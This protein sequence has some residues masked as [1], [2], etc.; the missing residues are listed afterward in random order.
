MTDH[1]DRFTDSGR[2]ALSSAYDEAR[3]LHHAYIGTEHLLLGL[4]AADDSVAGRVLNQAG[5]SLARARAAVE[6]IVGPGDS[7]RPEGQLELT[8]RAKQVVELAMDEARRLGHDDI[9]T[10]HLTLGLI[11]EGEGVA[12]GVLNSMK[13]DLEKLRAE[14]LADA[15]GTET[16]A[17]APGLTRREDVHL[18]ASGKPFAPLGDLRRVLPIARRERIGEAELTFL[19]L[20]IY[21]GGAVL[22]GRIVRPRLDEQQ[23]MPEIQIEVADDRGTVYQALHAGGY[24]DPGEQR[25]SYRLFPSPGPTASHLRM[26]VSELRWRRPDA[27]SQRLSLFQVDRGPWV[28]TIP[29]SE[30]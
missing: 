5:L 9:G 17:S 19:S 22:N 24:R 21:D 12:V 27:A 28:F 7:H 29:L 6:A 2:R 23:L 15:D 3:R 25:F 13:I 4:L 11:R 16:G 1:F 20:E 30:V 8:L 18:A 10:A 26:E 14:V